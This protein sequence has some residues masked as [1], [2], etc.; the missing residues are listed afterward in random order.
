MSSADYYLDGPPGGEHEREAT[1]LPHSLE[2]TPRATRVGGGM[3][4]GG[5]GRRSN[6]FPLERQ[7]AES[8]TSTPE[9][10]SSETG[11]EL[12]A[13]LGR[14]SRTST[15]SSVSSTTLAA[16]AAERYGRSAPGC[17]SC[18]LP[19]GAAAA[20]AAALP[21]PIPIPLRR[22]RDELS[23][24]IS[25]S[26]ASAAAAGLP[27][28][29]PTTPTSRHS[30]NAS[31]HLEHSPHS[32]QL[33]RANRPSPIL[34]RDKELQQQQLQQVANSFGSKLSTPGECICV[35][36]VLLSPV[37][38][39]PVR[40]ASAASSPLPHGGHR[41][42]N[43]VGSDSDG[44]LNI[45]WR[46][47][48][49]R[50]SMDRPGSRTNTPT[51]SPILNRSSSASKLA[52][53]FAANRSS[54]GSGLL[55]TRVLLRR[56]DSDAAD[57]R[58]RR[59]G[60]RRP[61]FMSHGM[62]SETSM[63]SCSS[64]TSNLTKMR[65]SLGHSD[66]QISASSLHAAA[67]ASAAGPSTSSGA[68]GETTS[69]AGALPAVR[70]RKDVLSHSARGPNSTRHSTAR[71]S[72]NTSTSPVLAPRARSPHRQL[73]PSAAGSSSGSYHGSSAAGIAVAGTSQAA[74]S[75][76]STSRGVIAPVPLRSYSTRS[77]S[78]LMAPGHHHH[79]DNRRWSLASLPSTSGY[80]TPG[81]NS[82]FSSQY[83]SNEQLCEA[84]DG[85]RLHHSQH[86]GHH[87]HA[88]NSSHRFDSNDSSVT[89]EEVAAVQRCESGAM[90]PHQPFRPRSRSLT[91]PVKL[92]GSEWTTNVVVRNSVYKERFP[93]A[94]QQ[95][96][97]KLEAFVRQ[98]APLSGGPSSAETDDVTSGGGGVSS[99]N[100][101]S[102][103]LTAE[104][105]LEPALLRLIADGATR[106]LHHQLVEIASDCLQRSRDD[107]ITCSYFCEMS[108]RLDETLNEA[109]QKTSGD[110]FDY[111]NK[112]VRQLLMI[113]SRPARLLE[114]L[115]FDPDEF[116]QLLEEAEGVVREQLGSGTA[117]VPDLPQYIIG[118]LGLD[119]DPLLEA[120]QAGACSPPSTPAI[121]APEQ[122]Q[123]DTHRAPCEDDLETIRLVSNG[124]YGAVYLV[125]HRETRQRFA[126]KKMNK[127]TLML[128]NQIDQV[129]AERDILTMTDNPFV[130]SFYGSFETRHHL[131]MLMEYVEGGDCASLLKNAGTLPIDLMKLYVAETILAIEYLHSYG[132]VHRDLKPDNLLITAMGHIKLTDFGLSKIGL[133]NR[134]TLVA[135]GVAD[136]AETQQFKDKQLC[137]T[138]EYIA[139]EVIIRQGY[140]KPVDWWALGIISYEFLVGIVPFFGE[141]PEDLFSKVISE[142][143][144][145]P[146]GEEALPPAAE[147]LIKQ[148]LEKNPIERLGS[149]TGA[150]ELMAHE[151]FAD[152][153]F[154]GLLRQKAEFVPQLE[155]E[156]DTSYFDSRT[157]RYNHDAG[158]S[159]GEEEGGASSAPMFHSFST[160]SPRHSIVGLEPGPLLP[161]DRIAACTSPLSHEMDSPSPTPSLA[162]S[163]PTPSPSAM[164]RKPPPPSNQ[165]SEEHSTTDSMNDVHDKYGQPMASAVLLRRRFSAQRQSNLS[166]SSSGTT[167]TG[168]IGT[169]PSSTDS[170]MDAFAFGERRLTHGE[171]GRLRTDSTSTAASSISRRSPLPRFAI[172][173]DPDEDV[174]SPLPCSSGSFSSAV[175]SGAA[176]AAAA[177][178]Q[179]HHELSPVDEAVAGR[180]RESVDRLPGS[181]QLVIPSGA[182]S[183][184][185]SS[186]I[187]PGAASACSLSS[188]DGC[189]SL[190]H[191]QSTAGG[192]PVSPLSMAPPIV[193]RKGPFGFGFTIKSVRVYLGEH[194]DYYTIEHIVSSVD[195]RG[196][197][198]EAGLRCEDMIT[199]V[200][201][202]PV[203]NM[204]HPQL[205]NLMLSS[206][207]E[208]V[209]KVTPLAATGIREGGPRKSVGKLARKQKQPKCPKRRLPCEKKS[210]K[211]S[212][213][214][215]RLSGKRNANDIVPGSSSQK[216]TFMP[217]SVSS[218]DGVILQPAVP[219][220]APPT[221]VSPSL[222]YGGGGT[223]PSGTVPSPSLPQSSV[224]GGSSH[225]SGSMTSMGGVKG[226]MGKG[227][228]SAHKR[229]SDVGLT[230]EEHRS[231]LVSASSTSAFSP[232]NP[233]PTSSP[234]PS[235]LTGLKHSAVSPSP[236]PRS[237]VAVP[238]AA[239]AGLPCCPTL[240]MGGGGGVGGASAPLS[241]SPIP[242]SPLARLPSRP[243]S[244]RPEVP[245]AHTAAAA[246]PS[247]RPAPPPIPP[248][249]AARNL[250]QRLL[251]KD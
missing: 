21:P 49:N 58:R 108:Q 133:M 168:Y 99:R 33:Q 208:I 92:G 26:P 176:A 68:G 215:R 152:L 177:A 24:P 19:A 47:P 42:S 44:D 167:G 234:R 217:R 166:T 62:C 224:S 70:M 164:N 128:R 61:S 201:A 121:E 129:F 204:T 76:S 144:E 86:H 75:S 93:R 77:G 246:A 220:S 91:S 165:S 249:P 179:S 65:L 171:E 182:S 111:L 250:M 227:A 109:T 210:R 127:Q 149:V 189:S 115:E 23:S 191:G 185:A 174:N 130:V 244:P 97:E 101:K 80:G 240:S 175:F 52:A 15:A 90:T 84:L 151:F 107:T 169:A 88:G 10:R 190:E 139:P 85:M 43:H 222:V 135:E 25:C 122:K 195:E 102:M 117:R 79:H 163:R 100:R 136:V 241:T 66:P 71:R 56:T 119:R 211:P 205:M 116:Y 16:E 103:V 147:S 4:E 41:S 64:S 219:S 184:G 98:N 132:V 194:S 186:K 87:H 162:S 96:E 38:S 74:P 243:A 183:S 8:E 209:L 29:P 31:P 231:P 57:A 50:R 134:T 203:H 113:V 161:P 146:D 138:P 178:Q 63:D 180:N 28:P 242:V 247:D 232:A 82:A 197:A 212:S 12:A 7:Y 137:G 226:G 170:S 22:D 73:L 95:M 45:V 221:G 114:C 81:S 13:I 118:K 1:P 46:L 27:P 233:S 37:L 140:G 228:A 32:G 198:F 229:M 202:Q 196:P 51:L 72:L 55:S 131:C 192:A 223:G 94:K 216:Q 9:R 245:A 11:D 143:V 206:G 153:D 30:A 238:A 39:R 237:T 2:T 89:N 53:S 159:Q 148:L 106:F 199:A 54:S 248:P 218:Q 142:E 158:D 239:A 35:P 154:N 160:A 3:R 112:L 141:S 213:L 18:G 14:R 6:R 188:Y 236:S 235:T 69:T 156:E 145:Y 125:R 200:N 48:Q 123:D 17:T 34:L 173:C 172:S 214:L 207:C 181:L 124:A 110:S 150:P 60:K 126:L 193:I 36:P 104:N 5:G 83:S 155:N 251:N 20:A 187:S 78:S 59:K 230:R 40:S 157:D 225:S 105:T 120:E 67:A